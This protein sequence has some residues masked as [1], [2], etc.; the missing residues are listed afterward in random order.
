MDSIFNDKRSSINQILEDKETT[1]N[2]NNI[3]QYFG[4]NKKKYLF[5]DGKIQ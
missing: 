1:L 3:D 5:N 4:N 2:E